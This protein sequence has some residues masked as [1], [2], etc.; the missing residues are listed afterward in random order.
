MGP[1]FR[2]LAV[3]AMLSGA[4]AI[5]APQD[6][7]LLS[8]DWPHM[9][10]LEHLQ[11]A[12][13]VSLDPLTRPWSR[14]AVVTA[15]ERVDTAAADATIM[16]LVKRLRAD[17]AADTMGL[18]VEAFVGAL[19]ASDAGRWALR[20]APDSSSGLFPLAGITASLRF[21]H[22]AL[23]TSPRIDNR[24]RSDPDYRGKKDRFV[25]GRNPEAYVRASWPLA[26]VF[27]GQIDR[28]WG[29]EGIESLVLSPSPYT[30]DHF[31]VRLGP[32]RLRL[33]LL[34][35]QLDAR[36]NIDSTDERKR[37]L[38]LHR[39]VV[40]PT[41]R[42]TVS[43]F[44]AALYA[45]SRL[46]RS[47]EPWYLNPANLFLLAQTDGVETS[48][49]LLGADVVHRGDR[50]TLA[51]QAYLDDFQV[52][53]SVTGDREPPG[54]GFTL[55]ASGPAMGGR[56]TWHALYTRVTNL[57]Y[58]TPATE[59]AYLYREVGIGRN[60]ADYDQATLRMS[61]IAHPRLLWGAELSWLRQGEGD[62]R[63]AYPPESL[64]AA[65]PTIFS[66]TVERTIRLAGRADWWPSNGIVLGSELGVNL[67]N[68]AGHV[69][70]ASRTRWVWRLRAEIRRRWHAALPI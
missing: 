41:S 48:N 49:A 59:E 37:Y 19:A 9:A 50:L 31:F 33:E 51:A 58:R 28:N 8:S 63:A 40:Q 65:T 24:L 2:T 60:W 56:A 3:L 10:A 26:E 68:N 42:L 55:T 32:A 6:A 64:F 11:R 52:D 30:F 5:A 13:V 36:F 43:L 66:G 34:A 45:D 61:L 69:A 25:S 18:A 44:E 23:V 21:P 53:D 54:Y 4:P 38:S 27:V 15:L 62:P 29:P 17:L 35:T 70:S 57:A 46:E 1:H 16:Q 67:A 22:V 14:S 12:A 20:P 7:R 39:L 47:F